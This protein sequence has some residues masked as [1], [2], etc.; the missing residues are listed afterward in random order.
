[1]CHN[2]KSSNESHDAQLQATS[3]AQS[4]SICGK[5]ETK[6]FPAEKMVPQFGSCTLDEDGTFSTVLV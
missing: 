6:I 3:M 1:M 2:I 4:K 5:I